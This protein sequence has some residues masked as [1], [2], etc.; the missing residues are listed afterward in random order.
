MVIPE[1]FN[2]DVPLTD[3][4][5]LHLRKKEA[6]PTS[7]LDIHVTSAVDNSRDQDSD[8]EVLEAPPTAPPTSNSGVPPPLAEKPLQQSPPVPTQPEAMPQASP[9]TTRR[10]LSQFVP[11]KPTLQTVRDSGCRA[12]FF[13]AAGVVNTLTGFVEE[14]MR[15]KPEPKPQDLLKTEEESDNE[16]LYEVSGHYLEHTPGLQLYILLFG[17]S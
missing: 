12:P 14:R 4:T 9:P 16:D 10:P 2:L 17:F 5:P 11:E 1:C 6:T 13:I 3:Y 8:V 7:S 15:F